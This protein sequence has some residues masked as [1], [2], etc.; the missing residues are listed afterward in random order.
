MERPATLSGY[1]VLVIMITSIALWAFMIF[2]TLAHLRQLAGGLDP[3][4]TRPFGYGISQARAFLDALGADGRDFYVNVQL[5]LDAIYPATYAVSRGMV[6]WW[7]TASG[8]LRDTP[9]PILLRVALL[10]P[11]AATAGFDYAENIQIGRMLAAGPTVDAS[12]IETASR[13]TVCKSFS[14]AANEAGIIILAVAA[15]MR[16]RRR[17]ER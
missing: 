14:A 7:L 1:W 12:V 8:R 6:L 9:V 5:R 15:A 16:W 4:D 2:G 11:T 17:K 13:M 10:I 3:F